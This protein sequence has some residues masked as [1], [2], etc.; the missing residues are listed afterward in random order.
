MLVQKVAEGLWRWA[1]P[2]PAWKPEFDRPGGWGRIVACIYAEFDEAVVLIDPL[3][4]TDP[5]QIDKFW[6]ALDGDVARLD[7]PLTILIGSVDHGRSADAVA[8]RYRGAGRR[9]TVIGDAAIRDGVS[10][11]LDATFEAANLPAGLR[12]LPVIGMSPGERAFFLGPWKAAV[13]ADAVIGA[14]QGRVRVAPPFWGVKTDEGRATYDR[15][16]RASVRA[17]RDLAPEILLPSHGEP[18][19]SG[20]L[21]AL[22]DALGAPAWGEP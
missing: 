8:D 13:F 22:D 6:K 16:F 12:A 10:C 17:I 20:G 19:L 18:V 21:A 1:V 3:L 9:V 4:P 15:E 5:A 2:H 7:R 11:R 14:G